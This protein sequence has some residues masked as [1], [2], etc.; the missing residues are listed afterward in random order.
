LTIGILL[1]KRYII[2]IIITIIIITIIFITE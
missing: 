1:E 2:I